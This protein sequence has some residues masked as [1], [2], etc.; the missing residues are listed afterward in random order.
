MAAL[1][2]LFVY[3]ETE[4]LIEC[5]PFEG[6]RLRIRIG[7]PLPRTLAQKTV[8]RFFRVLY[9]RSTATPRAVLRKLQDIALV[10]LLFGAGLRVGE[11]AN[12]SAERIDL[13]SQ[14]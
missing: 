6:L 8:E 13:D 3:A 1:R 2:S 10:E 12:L 14:I 5:S 4:K 7:R 11:V 9:N